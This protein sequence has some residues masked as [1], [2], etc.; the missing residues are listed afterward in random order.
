MPA[1][2]VGD[3]CGGNWPATQLQMRRAFRDGLS[4]L[5]VP[6]VLRSSCP[7][8]KIIGA[9]HKEYGPVS[10]EQLRQWVSEGRINGA[11]RVQ[12]E[13]AD[14]WKP[15]S[16]LPEFAGV[17]PPPPPPSMS[18]PPAAPSGN[19]KMAIWSMVLGALSMFQCCQIILGPLAI[20][21]GFV[22]LSKIK[23]N[24]GQGGSGFAIAG[25]IMGVIGLLI[26][27]ALTIFV[28]SNPGFLQN[29]QNQLN[30]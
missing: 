7:M 5:D 22:A 27:I 23:A 29:F 30:H 21:L 18:M 10:A 19:N 11:T 28:L 26:G 14:V 8:Y 2:C 12:A 20:I 13:G 16:E 17:F 24:P 1:D 4:A 3:K 15:I 9:D 6:G 25:I